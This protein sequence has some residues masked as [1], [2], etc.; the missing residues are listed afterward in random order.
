MES[1][2]SAALPFASIIIPTR[3]R[4][5]ALKACLRALTAQDFP[6]E[7]FEVIVVNDGGREALPTV[8]AEFE[9]QLGLTLLSQEGTG[10][11]SA[12]NKG[13][14]V[15]R[16]DLLVFTDDD[17]V[18]A[19]TWL[20][21]LVSRSTLNPG[22]ALGG[23]TI[24]ALHDNVYAS[25]SQLIVDAVYAYYNSSPENAGFFTTNNLAVPRDVFRAIGGF[26][27][28]FQTAEDREFCDRWRFQGFSLR[29]APEAKIHHRNDMGMAGYLRQHFR[30]GRGAFCFQVARAARRRRRLELSPAEFYMHLL[31]FPFLEQRGRRAALMELLLLL[32]QMISAAGFAAEMV[33]T[34]ATRIGDHD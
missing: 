4:P 13:A 10:P 32:S 30:Y 5:Q 1:P 24:N 2:E 6:G 25:A 16:G 31:R 20:R 9:G 7:R 12:R 29:Y 18:P 11:A 14:G 26:D 27:E 23:Q 3:D 28:T 8:L 34:L 15:A 33:T 22:H 21:A 19:P 17:C